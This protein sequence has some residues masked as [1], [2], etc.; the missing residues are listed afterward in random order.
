[1][2]TAFLTQNLAWKKKYYFREKSGFVSFLRAS[3][4][5]GDFCGIEKKYIK[6]GN[7][8]NL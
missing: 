2:V 8:D 7:Y 4:M 6:Y 5:T 1:M 3:I